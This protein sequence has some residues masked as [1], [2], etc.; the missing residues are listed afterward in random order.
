MKPAPTQSVESCVRRVVG[1]VRTAALASDADAL[2]EITDVRGR[3]ALVHLAYGA[4]EP[5]PELEASVEL[6]KRLNYFLILNYAVWAA[7]GA[8]SQDLDLH[9]VLPLPSVA[10]EAL[11]AAGLVRE[12]M[13]DGDAAT[14]MPP[15]DGR[16][17]DH[18]GLDVLADAGVIAVRLADLRRIGEAV[19]ALDERHRA[20]LRAHLAA[21]CTVRSVRRIPAPRA[22]SERVAALSKTAASWL[23]DVDAFAVAEVSCG[24]ESALFVHTLYAKT[25]TGEE[26]CPVLGQVFVDGERLGEM[27]RALP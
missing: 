24:S 3:I 6:A 10:R 5:H 20:R 11:V 16:A 22:E 15:G 12:A 18:G 7:F 4:S 25:G 26:A 8:T 23:G 21:P 17:D 14:P 19:K 2:A 27:L 9:V 1:S 13:S